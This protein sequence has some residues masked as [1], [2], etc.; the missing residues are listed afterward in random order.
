MPLAIGILFLL[1]LGYLQKD[2]ALS[3][4]NDFSQLYAAA[5]LAGSDFLYD[6]AANLEVIRGIH[7]FT[8]D[9]VVYTRPPFYAALLAPLGRLPYRVAYAIFSLTS[10]VAFLWLVMRFSR[11]TPAL[12]FFAAFSIPLIS[13]LCGGQ[14][15]ALLAAVVGVAILLL[16]SGRDFAGGAV[17]ALCTI[18]FHLFLLVPLALLLARRWHV[19]AGGL[20][21]TAALTILGTAVN[22]PDS[23][24]AYVQVLRDPWIHP[25]P[26]LMPNLHGMVAT[27]GGPAALEYALVAVLGGAL[28]WIARRGESFEFLLAM[29]LVAS[30]LA[31]FHSGIMDDLLLFPAAS[32][33]LRATADKL[34]RS[35]MGLSLTPVPYLLLMTQA[36][37]YS[38]LLAV[39]LFGLVMVAA[40]RSRGANST[41]IEASRLSEV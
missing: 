5:R 19:L 30:L 12:A 8:M 4:Q 2:R 40:W 38:V 9:T 3:G 10:L 28:V 6:R 25:D 35:V 17:L 27:L 16:R 11:E 7:G 32:L 23:L 33:F 20:A 36:K 13:A 1:L 21:G 22:G 14:D 39:M 34:L 37:P 41:A 24:L 18:K 15:T 31:S 29:A 26:A